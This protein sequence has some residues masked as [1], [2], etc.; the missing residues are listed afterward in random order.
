MS[1]TPE[2]EEI[3]PT[4]Q[5]VSVSNP[6]PNRKLR[7]A[8]YARVSTELEEQQNSYKAQ[9]NHYTQYIQSNPN[10]EF[11]GVFADEGISGTSMKKRDAFNRMVNLAKAGKIDVIMTKSI[12]RFSRNTVDALTTVREL[13]EHGVE[14]IFE[15]EHIHSLDPQGE[16]VL[17]IM[18]SLAQDEIRSLSQNI[19]WGQQQSMKRGKVH[20]AYSRFLGYKKGPDGRPEIVEDEAKIVRDIYEKYLAGMT[21]RQIADDL[22]NRGITTPAGKEKWAPSTVL[23]ILTNEKYKGEAVLQKTFSENYLTK[24][25]RKNRGER[26]QYIVRHSHEPIIDP[27]VFEEVQALIEKRKAGQATIMGAHPFKGKLICSQCGSTYYQRTWRKHG[28]CE[29]F[30]RWCCGTRVK[31]PEKCDAP[32]LRE[33]EIEAAFEK[34]RKQIG[35][36]YWNYTDQ[37]WLDTV[38]SVTVHP[39]RR[40]SFRFIDGKTAEVTPFDTHA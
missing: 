30:T 32:N 33:D 1:Y 39:D 2:V 28:E 27:E 11:V 15:K 25:V 38:E 29:H 36:P 21:I 4:I 34:A 18:I 12:S 16:V 6:S 20:L 22:T 26:K 23:S 19:I 17:T 31:T 13:G 8:A 7:V 5:P 3:E 10:W 37:Y 14:V 24:K 35:D 9:V 40:F